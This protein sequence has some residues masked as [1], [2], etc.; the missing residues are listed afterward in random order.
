KVQ[1]SKPWHAQGC[2]ERFA[3]SETTFSGSPPV[4]K[5]SRRLPA[6]PSLSRHKRRH[7]RG[8]SLKLMQHKHLGS[9]DACR[10]KRTRRQND[11]ATA[12]GDRKVR[13]RQVTYLL[14]QQPHFQSPVTSHQSPP[15]IPPIKRPRR[16][17]SR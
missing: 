11:K 16:R 14:A 17:S 3:T 2:R 15:L 4:A 10:L 1:K 13:L 9:A 12:P 7:D 6:S 5:G 8:V